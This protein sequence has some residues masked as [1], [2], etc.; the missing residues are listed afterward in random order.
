[1]PMLLLRRRRWHLVRVLRCV[2]SLG[3]RS[4][5]GVGGGGGGDRSRGV[6]VRGSAIPPLRH[7]PNRQQPLFQS[8]LKKTG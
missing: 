7:D 4:G 6:G 1:M 8:S 2:L 5:G 3:Q